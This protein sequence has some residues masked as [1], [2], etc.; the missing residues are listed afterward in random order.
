VELTA[1]LYRRERAQWR[2]RPDLTGE[3]Q[4]AHLP[5]SGQRHI[6]TRV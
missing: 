3:M 4:M 6:P 2:C 1:G 5:P